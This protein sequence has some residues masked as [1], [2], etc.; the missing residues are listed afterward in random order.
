MKRVRG[1]VRQKS[2]ESN[3]HGTQTFPPQSPNTPLF[4]KRV[5]GFGGKRKTFFLVKKSFSLPPD[6]HLLFRNSD[7]EAAGGEEGDDAGFAIGNNFGFFVAVL[8]GVADID[9]NHL[10]DGN[11]FCVGGD[12]NSGGGDTVF[13]FDITD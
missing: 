11:G 12:F 8:V 6:S 5:R 9:H 10:I 4:L 13:V 1:A 3:N 7:D 2:R